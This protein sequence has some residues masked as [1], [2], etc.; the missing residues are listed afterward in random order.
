MDLRTSKKRKS[1]S[2]PPNSQPIDITEPTS[3]IIKSKS[4]SATLFKPPR[5][6]RC[7]QEGTEDPITLDIMHMLVKQLEKRLDLISAQIADIIADEPAS[8]SAEL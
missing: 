3:D 6:K 4:K 5:K 7:L 2:T 8:Q 1:E